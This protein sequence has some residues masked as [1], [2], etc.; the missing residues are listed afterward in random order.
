MRNKYWRLTIRLMFISMLSLLL[1]VM[2]TGVIYYMVYK[3]LD[4]PGLR[5]SAIWAAEI[6]LLFFER[7]PW[8]LALPVILVLA[9]LLNFIF[10][11]KTA[12]RMN[13]IFNA[14]SNIRENEYRVKLPAGNP[15]SLG[16]LERG[17]NEMALQIT[18]SFNERKAVERSKDDFIVNIAH[19]LRTPLTSIIG[20]LA[21]I[22]EKQLD[23]EISAKYAAIAFE[24]SKQLENLVDALFDISRFTAVTISVNKEE[25]NLRKFLLQK[26]DELFPQL[27]AANMEIRLDIPP[28]IQTIFVDGDL[29]ARAFDNL[30]SNAIRYAKD[31]KTIDIRARSIKNGVIISFITHANPIPE[32]E[33]ERVFDK[34]YR[35]D[36][37]RASETGGAGLGLPISRRIVE[38]HGGT[39]T[40]RQA[41]G[42]TA[43]DII[44]RN[45]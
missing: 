43:F 14:V 45:S 41:E 34:L 18:D 17:I 36:K 28:E 42:G 29:M 21:F 44:L 33:L 12:N 31:G 32:S 7:F 5:K 1:A 22:S 4:I 2:A 20:Y 19:D 11:R 40:A 9:V 37:S 38:L 8:Y 26:Q 27:A 16:D 35:L 25:V 23:P 3:T 15:D 6:V 10:T 13:A 30:M 39:L 24:K